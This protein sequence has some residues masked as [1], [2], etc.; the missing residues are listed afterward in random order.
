MC[1]C[2]SSHSRGAT[3]VMWGYKKCSVLKVVLRFGKE[4]IIPEILWFSSRTPL[5]STIS[6]RSSQTSHSLF[7]GHISSYLGSR[8][9]G[10]EVRTFWEM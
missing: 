1:T 5:S 7:L 2:M 3:A 9:E 6:S 8:I 4:E 10:K